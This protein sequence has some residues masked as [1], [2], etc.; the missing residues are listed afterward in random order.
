MFLFNSSVSIFESLSLLDI[1]GDADYLRYRGL[2]EFDRAMQYIEERYEVCVYIVPAFLIP[3]TVVFIFL[4]G[5]SL[6]S[7]KT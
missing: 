4:G 1:Q 6:S 2:Q 7:C 5:I 3:C